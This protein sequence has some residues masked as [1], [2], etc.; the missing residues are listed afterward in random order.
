VLSVVTASFFYSSNFVV[1]AA[2]VCVAAFYFDYWSNVLSP[3]LVGAELSYLYCVD[4][5]LLL[6]CLPFLLYHAG[7]LL[8]FYC[9]VLNVLSFCCVELG[10]W[11]PVVVVC[12]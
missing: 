7:L 3:P 1:I 6:P 4:L 2:L 10:C 9:V 8:L 12:R 5:K 11:V